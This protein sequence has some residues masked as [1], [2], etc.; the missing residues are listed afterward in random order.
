MVLATH[1]S[2]REERLMHGRAGSARRRLQPRAL[3]LV[4]ARRSASSRVCCTRTA[5]SGLMPARMAGGSAGGTGQVW[6][7]PNRSSS[8]AAP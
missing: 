1:D 6:M 2:V 8:S 5:A 7:A 4:P 3:T